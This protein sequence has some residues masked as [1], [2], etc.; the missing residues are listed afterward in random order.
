VGAGFF[1]KNRAAFDTALDRVNAAEADAQAARVLL[2]SNVARSYFQWLRLNDQLELAR[3]SPAQR[4]ETLKLVQDRVN[5]G[6]DTRLELR[7][8]EGRLPAARLQLETLQ[9]QAALTKNALA[10]LVGEPNTALVPDQRLLSAIDK[11]AM[12]AVIPADRLTGWAGG[13]T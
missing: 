4:S 3:R 13:P 10:A 7:Q 9:E 5:A 2:A 8:S 1:G 11:V 6:L 12:S